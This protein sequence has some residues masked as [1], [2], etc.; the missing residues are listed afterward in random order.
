[1]TKYNQDFKMIQGEDKVLEI[2]VVDENG[3]AKAITGATITWSLARAV[4]DTP[5]I[6]KST[7]GSGI[8]I[9]DGNNGVFQVTIGD[10]DTNDMNGAYI[11]EA[12]VVDTSG[13]KNTVLF[14][15]I[16]IQKSL[17]R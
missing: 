17:I 10:T 5:L 8:S 1:M 2:T 3:S 16:Q 9:T 11:H 7:G 13:R 6:T 14:G 4:D 12:E 15:T